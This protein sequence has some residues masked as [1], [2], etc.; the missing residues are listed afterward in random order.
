MTD[1]TPISKLRRQILH[2]HGLAPEPRT[3]RLINP[4]E[5]PS[6]LRKT[7]T[8]KMLEYK[9]RIQLEDFISHGSLSDVAR[10]F[11]SDN[12]NRA[13]I[14][15]WRKNFREQRKAIEEAKFFAQF[16]EDNNE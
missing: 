14:S 2:R 6:T 5:M 7:P 9:Y 3:K 10:F 8:Q 13:T 15:K 11:S 4:A 1:R 12:I 16:K